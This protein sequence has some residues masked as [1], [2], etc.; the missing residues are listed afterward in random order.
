MGGCNTAE[1]A[2]HQCL[3]QERLDRTSRNREAAKLQQERF[4]QTKQKYDEVAEA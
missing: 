4:E 3:R 2:L 1:Q